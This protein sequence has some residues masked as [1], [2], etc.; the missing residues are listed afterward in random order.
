MNDD[1]VIAGRRQRRVPVPRKDGTF[2]RWGQ[3]TDSGTEYTPEQLE[4][5]RAIDQLKQRRPFPT[6]C[7][8]LDVLLALGYR[9]APPGDT[10]VCPECG[11]PMAGAEV[12]ALLTYYPEHY[13]PWCLW[14]QLKDFRPPDPGRATP[15]LP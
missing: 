11:H 13:C 3:S 1:T 9:K 8:V 6:W 5:L 7:E 4:F 10:L 14:A 15:A 12:A 2:R